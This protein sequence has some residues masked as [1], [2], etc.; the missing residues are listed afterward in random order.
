[1]STTGTAPQKKWYEDDVVV[2]DKEEERQTQFSRAGVGFDAIEVK[3]QQ[4]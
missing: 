2:T 3:L 4:L 1:M